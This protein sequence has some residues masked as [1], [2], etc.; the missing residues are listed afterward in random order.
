MALAA[1]TSLHCCEFPP[2]RHASGTPPRSSS[3]LPLRPH[4]VD[5]EGAYDD[6]FAAG[7]DGFERVLAY[8]LLQRFR[9][10]QSHGIPCVL[11]DRGLIVHRCHYEARLKCVRSVHDLSPL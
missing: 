4:P 1:R 2:P 9:C 10:W 11:A 5:S 6:S 8:S 7:P 3:G